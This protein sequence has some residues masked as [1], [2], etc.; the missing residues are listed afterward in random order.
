MS[1]RLAQRLYSAPRLTTIESHS[2]LLDE[3][4]LPDLNLGDSAKSPPERITVQRFV[5]GKGTRSIATTSNGHVVVVDGQAVHLPKPV[6]QTWQSSI[7]T[8]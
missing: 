5:D 7:I 1:D 2:R 8:A 6:T 3:P 4:A